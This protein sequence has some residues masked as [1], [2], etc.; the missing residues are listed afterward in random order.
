MNY[1]CMDYLINYFIDK[2]GKRFDEISYEVN[3]LQDELEEL[4]DRLDGPRDPDGLDELRLT[5]VPIPE[6]V[7]KL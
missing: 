2:T 4:F 7:K 3:E 6:R 5:L 1:Y